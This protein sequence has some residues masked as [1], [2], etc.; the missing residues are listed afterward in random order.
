MKT[1]ALYNPNFGTL[2]PNI[3][4]K[5]PDFV[6]TS[7]P[8][9]LSLNNVKDLPDRIIMD[10]SIEGLK[11]H[12]FSIKIAGNIMAVIIEKKKELTKKS[13]WGN[14]SLIGNKEKYFYSIFERSDIFLPG[15]EIK[16]LISADYKD[17]VLKICIVKN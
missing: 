11:E 13:T 7:T 17:G 14:I 8:A 9:K 12:N 2:I 4:T 1:A 6:W 16:E 15:S 10:V 5:Q 3:I